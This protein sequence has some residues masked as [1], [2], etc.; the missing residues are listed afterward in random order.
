MAR[1]VL[2]VII[3]LAFISLGMP[4]ALLG[5]SWPLI[6]QEW[7]MSLDYA[8]GISLVATVGTISSCL[9]SGRMLSRFGAGSVTFISGIL[10]GSALLGFAYSPSYLWFAIFAM[11]L[12]FGAGSVDTALNHYVSL[13]FEAH[14]MNWLHSFWGV[15]AMAG[16]MVMAMV[17]NVTGSW[18]IG[19]QIIAGIQLTLAAIIL[20]SLPIWKNQNELCTCAPTPSAFR[21]VKQPLARVIMD[22]L[23]IKGAPSA[24]LFFMVYCAAEAAVGLWGSSYLILKRGVLMETAAT[25]VALF[26]GGITLGRVFAGFVS[27]SLNNRARIWLGI[28][29]SFLGVM[30]LVFSSNEDVIVLAFVLLGLGFAPLF[31][32]MIHETPR[33]FGRRH[34]QTIIGYQIASSYFGIAA[35]PPLLGIVIKNTDG[36]AFPVYIGISLVVL[37]VLSYGLNKISYPQEFYIREETR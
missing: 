11:F 3:Y 2:L 6:R 10:T 32:A 22:V 8:G 30:L 16:P 23:R 29:I 19:Y 36:S 37:C 26:Y 9:L 21:E 33:R 31:P 7:Q 18:R 12:G 24:L 13:N 28:G 5:V 14:H 1:K 34:A 25:R 4:D 17:L 35:L 27:Y 20:I 15:G